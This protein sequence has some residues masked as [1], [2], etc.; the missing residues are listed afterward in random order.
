MTRSHLSEMTALCEGYGTSQ[1][2]WTPVDLGAAIAAGWKRDPLATSATCDLLGVE[3]H[4]VAAA[5]FN[6]LRPGSDG[7]VHFSRIIIGHCRVYGVC[8]I[9]YFGLKIVCRSG[10]RQMATCV[11][12]RSGK[13]VLLHSSGIYGDQ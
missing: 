3:A 7:C 2:T 13:S 10:S 9:D 11:F 6:L 1:S 8:F 5:Y 4:S 12:K